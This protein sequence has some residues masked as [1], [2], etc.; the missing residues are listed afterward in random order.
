M[1]GKL[2]WFLEYDINNFA[3]VRAKGGKVEKKMGVWR[4]GLRFLEQRREWRLPY[5][6][7]AGY[8]LLCGELEEDLRVMIRLFLRYAKEGV[9]K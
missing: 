5:L 2:K 3:C 4:I 6:L 7:Y 8:L 9:C 1:G